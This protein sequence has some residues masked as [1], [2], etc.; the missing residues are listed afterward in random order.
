[1]Q[2]G[3]RR[4]VLGN[5]TDE[6][7]HQA[8]LVPLRDGSLLGACLRLQLQTARGNR[9]AETVQ[10]GRAGLRKTGLHGLRLQRVRFA[11]TPWRPPAQGIVR[12]W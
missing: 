5:G 2:E 8:P 11:P 7:Q 9:G 4:G 1:M 12:A 6:G 10:A 3:R